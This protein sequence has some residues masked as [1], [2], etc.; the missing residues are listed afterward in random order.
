MRFFCARLVRDEFV[1]SRLTSTSS[2]LRPLRIKK[3]KVSV[4]INRKHYTNKKNEICEVL[5][6][7]ANIDSVH[8]G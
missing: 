6:S 4:L 1:E 5:C 7:D 2:F 3:T 8:P